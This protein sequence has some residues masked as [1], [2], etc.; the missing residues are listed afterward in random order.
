MTRASLESL[1]IHQDKIQEFAIGTSGVFT[2]E[3]WILQTTL[4]IESYGILNKAVLKWQAQIAIY[5]TKARFIVD[6]NK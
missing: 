2:D 4:V 1:Y 3:W 5:K 6:F